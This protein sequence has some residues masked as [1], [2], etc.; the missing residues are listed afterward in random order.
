MPALPAKLSTGIFANLF[1]VYS[2]FCCEVALDGRI[3]N[4]WGNSGYFGL[5]SLK[6]GT[7]IKEVPF[8]FGMPLDEAWVLIDAQTFEDHHCNIHYTPNLNGQNFLVFVPTQWSI[9]RRRD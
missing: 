1:D 9:N 8:L 6:V 5:H 2:L 4:L 3:E 7:D